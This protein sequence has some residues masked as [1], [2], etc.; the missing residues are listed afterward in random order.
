MYPSTAY[1]KTKVNITCHHTIS[2]QRFR[3]ITIPLLNTPGVGR[4][5]H[6]H[7]LQEETKQP[8]L[9]AFLTNNKL[10]CLYKT[11]FQWIKNKAVLVLFLLSQC[12]NFPSPFRVTK[13]V[14]VL[15]STD[16][17]PSTF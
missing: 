2:L 13:P 12:I 3:L 7:T 10:F 8:S 15:Q 6:C 16:K 9:T 1:T 5:L 17:I 11:R 4:L 14:I